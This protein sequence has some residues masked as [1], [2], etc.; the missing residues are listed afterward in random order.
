[1]RLDGQVVIVTGAGRGIG[2]ATARLLAEAGAKVAVV[3]RAGAEAAVEGLTATGA[4]ALAVEAD[5]SRAGDM[6][7]MAQAVLARWGRVDVLVNNAGITADARVSRLTEEAFTRVL[8]VNLK[9]VL[10]ATQAVL[11]AMRAQG[12]GKLINAA[13]TVGLHGN[14]GQTNYAA[15]KGGVIAMT[16]TWAKELGPEGITANAVAPGFVLTEMTATVPAKVLEAARERTP[17]RRL[18]HPEDLARVYLFLASPLADFVNGQVLTVDG[19][20]SL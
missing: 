4:E 3:D 2:A 14:F 19:G 17:L 10:L 12:R 16:K 1:M 20:M 6:A 8:D 5:V 15:A 9:G 7:H 18:G 11:P 13:S